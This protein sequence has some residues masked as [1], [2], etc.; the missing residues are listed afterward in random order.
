[1]TCE[2]ENILVSCPF[3]PTHR[4][5][6]H[7]IQSH[8]QKCAKN[9]PNVQTVVCPFDVTHVL[10]PRDLEVC[11]PLFYELFLFEIHHRIMPNAVQIVPL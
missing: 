10:N 11:C 8:L 1:M 3:E 4:I 2:P 9:H 7:R 6:K 5:F